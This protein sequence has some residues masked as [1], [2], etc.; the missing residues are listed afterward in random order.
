MALNDKVTF[1][2]D[3]VPET[4]EQLLALPEAS[5]DTPFK[6]AALTILALMNFERDSKQ[7]YEMLDFLNG[8]EDVSPYQRQFIHDR[9]DDKQYKVRS[10][11]E[12]TS[13]QNNYTPSMPLT[14]TVSEGVNSFS[15]E[16]W[17]YMYLKS[18]GADSPRGIRLR[19]KPSTGQWFFTEIQCL[20][21]IRTPVEE[22]PWA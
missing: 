4:M 19:K 9:L 7:T 16:S 15:E 3:A 10:Y 18:S 6:T 13:P 14:I 11:F 2:F 8:P 17:A 21:D 12:G 22:D 20:S 5:L 1:Q